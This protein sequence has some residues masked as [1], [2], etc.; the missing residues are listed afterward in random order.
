MQYFTVNALFLYLIAA[1]HADY[2]KSLPVFL[3][4]VLA[5]LWPILSA[6]CHRYEGGQHV[7][8]SKL[9]QKQQLNNKRKQNAHYVFILT[10]MYQ[11]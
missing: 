10:N 9:C 1:V 2:F 7:L 3:Y 4:D 5:H 11:P 6:M 8:L